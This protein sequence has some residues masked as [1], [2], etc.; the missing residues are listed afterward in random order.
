L[1]DYSW[2]WGTAILLGVLLVAIF[3][4][5]LMRRKTKFGKGLS[6]EASAR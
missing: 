4:I 6:S 3:L 2:L 1:V 5:Y